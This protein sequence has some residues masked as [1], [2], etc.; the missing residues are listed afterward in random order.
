MMTNWVLA[1]VLFSHNGGLTSLSIPWWPTQAACEQAKAEMMQIAVE[2]KDYIHV[3][4]F[5]RCLR[6]TSPE[7]E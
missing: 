3:P 6:Q 1:I 7:G 5:A 4:P 2:R